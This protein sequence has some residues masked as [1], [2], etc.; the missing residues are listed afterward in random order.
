[1]ENKTPLISIVVPIYNTEQYLNRCIESIIIQSF[2][3]LEIILVND[4][5]KDSSG[6]ICDEWAQKDTRVR[7]IHKINGGVTSARKTG[8]EY[9]A[10]EW[11]SFVDSDDYLPENAVQKLF[12]HIKEDVDIIGGNFEYRGNYSFAYNTFGEKDNVQYLKL[13][14]KHKVTWGPFCK[15]IKKTLFDDF[16]F[17]IPRNI[18]SGEDF[19]MNLRLG[20]KA[21]RIILLP[22]IVYY[23]IWRPGSAVSN[24]PMLNKNYRNAYSKFFNESISC[25]YRKKL[26]IAITCFW[27]GKY[28]KVLKAMIKNIVFSRKKV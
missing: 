19:I 14:L 3:H 7:V 13:L 6:T 28:W 2:Q 26:K 4:G 12:S 8:V 25:E 20:Q 23:Y 17:D 11:I 18:T 9:A 22:D 24:E 5:S 15:L 16:T 1:M 10:G 21:R 27:I